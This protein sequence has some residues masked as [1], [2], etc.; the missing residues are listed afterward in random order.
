SR[1][2]TD[3][4]KRARVGRQG[5]TRSACC[6]CERNR[7]VVLRAR[8]KARRCRLRS[9]RRGGQ[10]GARHRSQRRA[11]REETPARDEVE[12]PMSAT[13]ASPN[14]LIGPAIQL[15]VAIPI[16]MYVFLEWAPSL[17]LKLAGAVVAFGAA[18]LVSRG[19]DRLTG[20]TRS[21]VIILIAVAGL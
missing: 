13:K 5:N 12:A 11:G 6:A 15:A 4:S 21:I 20:A 10:R 19:V 17:P 18:R 9:R 1:T 14:R 16:L 8:R 7:E 2:G 3:R